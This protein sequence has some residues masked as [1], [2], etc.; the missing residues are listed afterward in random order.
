MESLDSWTFALYALPMSS[1]MQTLRGPKKNWDSTFTKKRANRVPR[2]K[3]KQAIFFRSKDAKWEWNVSSHGSDEPSDVHS[4]ERSWTWVLWVHGNVAGRA[5]HTLHAFSNGCRK[6]V[7][8]N[9]MCFSRDVRSQP[10]MGCQEGST[11]KAPRYWSAIA[12]NQ[13]TQNDI[14]F[15][16]DLQ[17]AHVSITYYFQN[18]SENQQHW[19]L[20]KVAMYSWISIVTECLEEYQIW[21]NGTYLW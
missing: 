4:D 16:R 2:L 11:D 14:L 5:D 8:K 21:L 13:I 3:S 1:C 15:S 7:L 6:E 18:Q 20:L 10:E 12:C 19:A 9:L 17:K